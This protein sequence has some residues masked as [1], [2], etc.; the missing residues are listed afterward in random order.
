MTKTRLLRRNPLNKVPILVYTRVPSSDVDVG[1]II[2]FFT[3]IGLTSSYFINLIEH[4]MTA[5]G[6]SVIFLMTVLF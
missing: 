1:K 4:N 6:V 5:Y 2:N 3:L